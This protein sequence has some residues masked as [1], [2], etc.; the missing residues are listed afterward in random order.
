MWPYHEKKSFVANS[1][2]FLLNFNVLAWIALNCH[3]QE[4]FTKCF[5]RLLLIA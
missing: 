2:V 4:V 3:H 1:K 5:E